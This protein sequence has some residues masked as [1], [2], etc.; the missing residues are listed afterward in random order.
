MSCGL[1][2]YVDIEFGMMTASGGRLACVWVTGLSPPISSEDIGKYFS[3]EGKVT[4]V[5]VPDV[6]SDQCGVVVGSVEDVKK[7][8]LLDGHS[9]HDD[10]LSIRIPTEAQYALID[11]MRTNTSEFVESGTDPR[12][13][14]LADAL[15]SLPTDQFSKLL[16]LVD[17]R[18][19]QMASQGVRVKSEV[20][21]TVND[22][23]RQHVTTS[24][25]HTLHPSSIGHQSQFS[26]PYYS[27]CRI[28]VFSGD[29]AKGEVD[30]THWRHEVQSLLAEACPTALLLPA[31]RRSLKGT[32]ADVLLNMGVSITEQDILAKFDVIFGNVLSPE[33]L[34]EEFYT[35]RQDSD[36][37]I[38]SWACR[39]ESLLAKAVANN[40]GQVDNTMMLRSKF[41]GGLREERIKN[42]IRHRYDSG[43]SFTVLLQSA[44]QIEREVQTVTRKVG[45]STVQAVDNDLSK[46][47]D[48]LMK[49]VD[50]LGKR[51]ETM[52]R[53]KGQRYQHENRPPP[54]CFFCGEMGHIRRRCPHFPGN[55]R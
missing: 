47:M 22:P 41:W 28:S 38:A 6:E 43:E 15:A 8:L 34:F 4:S 31:I 13:T 49:L 33:A 24:R 2:C 32:A 39:L 45:K 30:Y 18:K 46:K 50:S 20:S 51:I 27:Q 16:S 7:I 37:S 3:R 12:V 9:Y 54:I 23:V 36:E 21:D 26:V 19:T 44:R 53:D 52:E 1:F 29:N 40:T 48:T 42:G 10:T 5:V 35:A 17:A 25:D 55:G 14:E 11:D